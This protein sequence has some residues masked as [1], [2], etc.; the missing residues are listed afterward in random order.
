VLKSSFDRK[1]YS[2]VL[3]GS[4]AVLAEAKGLVA[5]VSIK[6]Q[7]ATA[8]L[9]REWTTHDAS[10]PPLVAAVRIRIDMLTKT[11]SSRNGVDCSRARANIAVGNALWDRAEAAFESGQLEDAVTLLKDAKMKAEAAEAALRLTHPGLG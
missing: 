5:A 1:D 3:A 2:A 4:P 8:G 11:K 9:V 10:L 7:E 6:K